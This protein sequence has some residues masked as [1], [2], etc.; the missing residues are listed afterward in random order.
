MNGCTSNIKGGIGFESSTAGITI[1]GTLDMECCCSNGEDIEGE[2][3]QQK[4]PCC[5]DS[6][7]I[8]NNI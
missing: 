2:G 6:P 8:V 1:N 3:H 4:H 7:I 5:H